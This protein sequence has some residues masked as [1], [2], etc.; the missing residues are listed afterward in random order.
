MDKWAIPALAANSSVLA[1]QNRRLVDQNTAL[2]AALAQKAGEIA[3]E[4]VTPAPIPV[5][6]EKNT[7][8]STNSPIP[9]ENKKPISAAPFASKF[10]NLLLKNDLFSNKLEGQLNIIEKKIGFS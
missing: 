5:I 3:I 7:L 6:S 8:D 4:P 10:K 9:S 1:I 2:R